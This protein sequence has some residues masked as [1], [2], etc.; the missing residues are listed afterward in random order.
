M[1]STL[2]DTLASGLPLRRFRPSREV[3]VELHEGRP[4]AMQMQTPEHKLVFIRESSGPWFLSG[5]WWDATAWQRELWE[6]S[7]EDG[8]LYQLAKER[9]RW[10]VEGVFG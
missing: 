9:E 10:V 1:P 2:P 3:Q 8:C 4:T 6:V 7:G 5:D